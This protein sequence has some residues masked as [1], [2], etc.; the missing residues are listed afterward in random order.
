MGAACLGLAC[1]DLG[2][3]GIYEV[4]G[5]ISGFVKEG[6]ENAYLGSGGNSEVWVTTI[7]DITDDCLDETIGDFNIE[8]VVVSGL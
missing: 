6:W 3:R 4:E 7:V 1:G 8:T 5:D 2:C